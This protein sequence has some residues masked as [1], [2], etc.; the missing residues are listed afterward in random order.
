MNGEKKNNGGLLDPMSKVE[1][2]LKKGL[3]GAV[4]GLGY[5]ALK[6]IMKAS[7]DVME[8][9]VQEQRLE[10][11]EHKGPIGR[12]IHANEIRELKKKRGKK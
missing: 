6:G 1:G 7:K 10:E 8:A 2:R 3:W 11:L 12:F 5:A 9:T 4:L